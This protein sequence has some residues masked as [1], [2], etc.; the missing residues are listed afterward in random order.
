MVFLSEKNIKK[1]IFSSSI[2]LVGIISTVFSTLYITDKY[3]ELGNDLPKIEENFVRQQKEMLHYAVSMQI[4]QIDFRRKQIKERLRESLKS[5]VHEAKAI[6]NHLFN[7]NNRNNSQEE[8]ENLVR[9]AL[10]P[11][12]FNRGHDYF[13]AFGMDGTIHFYPPDPSLEGQRAGQA[14][15]GEKLQVIH[16]LR[17]IVRHKGEGFLDYEWP[18]PNTNQ[19]KLF[20]K[21]SYVNYMQPYDWFIGS[22][23]YYTDFEDTT[24][25]EILMDI[26]K[27]M[28]A[29][30][31][32]Y[33]FLYEL[34]DIS[35]GDDFATLLVNP[36]RPD[37][38]GTKLS[39]SYR[40]AHGKEFRKEFLQGLR[41]KGEAYVT[42]WYK[43]PG[44]EEPKRKLSYFRLYPKWNWVVAKGVYLDD[45]EKIILKEKQTLEENVKNKLLVFSLL[46]VLTVS[47]VVAIAHLFTRG[48]HAILEEYKSIQQEQHQEL[49]R[50]N[51]HLHQQATIDPLTRIY[52]RQHFN[53]NLNREISR[54][55]RYRHSLSL[56]LLDIDHFKSINDTFGHLAG[57]AVLK[58]LAE[59]M[60]SNIR[61]SD[62]LARWGG[63][64]FVILALEAD[65]TS[66]RALAEKLCR[67]V[68]SHRFSISQQV[69]CSFGVTAYISDEGAM[70][71]INRADQALYAAKKTGRNRVET[72]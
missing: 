50:I 8:I 1:I 40:G 5:R 22:G 61:E 55:E 44:H 69:T 72:R 35:G 58:E 9:Q 48:I 7:Q 34:H 29:D 36:N 21:L 53:A 59:L 10:R 64:E 15:S 33:F 17:N 19:E 68:A 14:F 57:D 46:F 42:Y 62:L 4:N 26:E 24:K 52:N 63:E 11:L 65:R 39:D 27:S 51:M 3:L 66:A 20:K 16:N 2:I 32:D 43:K 18:V 56:V 49:E 37:L 23:A 31:R 28:G 13:F 12:R 45:L 60:R 41:Q 25:A 30:P 67:L 47:A 38:V 71:L 6:A 70:A 54:S